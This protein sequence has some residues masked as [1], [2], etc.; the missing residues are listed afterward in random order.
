MATHDIVRSYPLIDELLEARRNLFN[1][2]EAVYAGYR[3]HAY[4]ILNFAR[5]WVETNPDRDEKLAICAVFHDIAAWPNGNLDYLRR[6]RTRPTPT[7]TRPV[8][9]LGNPRCGP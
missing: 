5:Q 9:A 3:N 7:S 2:T 6:R 1:N 4:H 8:E